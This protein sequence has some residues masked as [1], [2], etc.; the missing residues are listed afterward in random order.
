VAH[1]VFDNRRQSLP[2]CKARINDF[3]AI[4]R[5]VAVSSLTGKL[6][7]TF[8]CRHN[9]PECVRRK[10][11]PATRSSHSSRPPRR[12]GRLP[13]RCAAW[14]SGASCS[15]VRNSWSVLSCFSGSCFSMAAWSPPGG[16][17]TRSI[18][19]EGTERTFEP[20]VHQDIC[21]AVGPDLASLEVGRPIGKPRDPA[22]RVPR[23]AGV[24]ASVRSLRLRRAGEGVRSSFRRGPCPWWASGVRDA[25]DN[26]L[27]LC[28]LHHRLLDSGVLG[29]SDD[30]PCRLP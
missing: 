11:L 9:P 15:R 7:R 24:R 8:R 16:R 14:L 30:H 21:E 29:L 12:W 10:G 1:L 27:C 20:S 13:E 3:S 25:V 17:P 22:F 28:S 5:P 26:G 4:V 23:L 2:I 18:N 19:Q 6:C